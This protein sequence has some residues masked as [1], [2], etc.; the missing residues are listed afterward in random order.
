M[1]GTNIDIGFPNDDVVSSYNLKIKNRNKWL[2]WAFIWYPFGTLC[3]DVSVG[4]VLK[5]I[6]CGMVD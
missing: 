4:G 6:R 2:K 5:P 1:D 3:I